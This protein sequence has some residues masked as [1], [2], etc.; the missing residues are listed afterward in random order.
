VRDGGA[1]IIP[2]YYQKLPLPSIGGGTLKVADEENMERARH[3]AVIVE[4]GKILCLLRGRI[5]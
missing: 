1:W 4:Q 5:S 2:E 3:A